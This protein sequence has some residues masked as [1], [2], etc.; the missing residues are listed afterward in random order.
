MSVQEPRQI[1]FAF[2]KFEVTNY[3][4]TLNWDKFAGV[5]RKF[6]FDGAYIPIGHRQKDRVLKLLVL[7]F[8]MLDFYWVVIQKWHVDIYNKMRLSNSRIDIYVTRSI[9]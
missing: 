3:F 2:S 1:W 6:D 4:S 9:Q 5:I 7:D 8:A